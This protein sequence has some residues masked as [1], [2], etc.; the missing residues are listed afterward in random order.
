ML[1]IHINTVPSW[2]F[3]LHVCAAIWDKLAIVCWGLWSLII[4]EGK[5]SATIE[6]SAWFGDRSAIFSFSIFKI[7][8]IFDH[9][10]IGP[11]I[12][13]GTLSWILSLEWNEPHMQ[14]FS[15]LHKTSFVNTIMLI[16]DLFQSSHSIFTY[17]MP[18]GSKISKHKSKRKCW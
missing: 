10:Y 7:S 5:T 1:P 17:R 4:G 2:S 6:P 3:L 11:N 12:G 8:H 18:R 15:S 13:S 14:L 16:K 9:L